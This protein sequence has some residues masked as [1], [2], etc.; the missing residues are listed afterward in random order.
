MDLKNQLLQE[1]SKI[2]SLAIRNYLIQNPQELDDFMAIFFGDV[3]RLSQRAAMVVSALF[4]YQKELMQPYIKDMILKLQEK[5]LHVAV[6]RNIVRILQE[7]EVE[8]DL[9]SGLFDRCAFYVQ[10]ASEAIAVKAF[11]MKVMVNACIRYPELKQEA[12]L[13][14]EEEKRRNQAKGIQARS[15]AMLKILERI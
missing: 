9:L 7:V 15:K 12:F 13:I 8:D 6:K 10:S 1:H 14:I 11:S 5:E 3:Y 4:D 2:N